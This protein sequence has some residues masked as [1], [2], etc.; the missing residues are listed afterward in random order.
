MCTEVSFVCV[1]Q[2]CTVHTVHVQ[3]MYMCNFLLVSSNRKYWR[4][5]GSV[6]DPGYTWSQYSHLKTLIGSYQLKARDSKP[7][8]EHGARS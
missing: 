7:W 8:T 6:R 1:L 2:H 3:Y 4:S 5:G